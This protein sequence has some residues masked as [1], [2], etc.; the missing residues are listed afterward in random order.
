MYTWL[1]SQS[2]LKRNSYFKNTGNHHYKVKGEIRIANARG[3]TLAAGAIPLTAAN[4]IPTMSRELKASLTPGDLPNGL[5]TV[6]VKVM[7][8]E[9]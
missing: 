8:E 7:K 2:S 9:G 1:L 4:V 5:Y 6:R 3:E